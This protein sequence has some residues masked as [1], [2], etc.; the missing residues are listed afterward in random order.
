MFNNQIVLRKIET[1]ST[2]TNATETER[3]NVVA[4]PTVSG[5][6]TDEKGKAL[7]G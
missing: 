4:L 6:I 7:P 3:E 1:P 5:T 2:T